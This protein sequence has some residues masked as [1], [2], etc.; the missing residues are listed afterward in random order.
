MSCLFEFWLRCFGHYQGWTSVKHVCVDVF[1]SVRQVICEF[2]QK[3]FFCQT[4][5]APFPTMCASSFFI[6]YFPFV[7]EIVL[8][9]MISSCSTSCFRS[10]KSQWLRL[11]LLLRG[12]NEKE[13]QAVHSVVSAEAVVPEDVEGIVVVVGGVHQRIIF[14]H[15]H[16]ILLRNHQ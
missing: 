4:L 9:T 14:H 7:T 8:W 3:I 10:L 15:Q 1:G 2:K 16:H 6:L 12:G 13:S 5:L 11:R